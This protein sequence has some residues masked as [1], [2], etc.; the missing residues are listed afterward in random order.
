MIICDNCKAEVSEEQL[1]KRFGDIEITYLECKECCTE[2]VITVTDSKLRKMLEHT[3]ETEKILRRMSL[4]QK[5]KI[6]ILKIEYGNRIGKAKKLKTKH[7]IEK[8]FKRKVTEAAKK[9][10]NIYEPYKKEYEEMKNKNIKYEKELKEMY[11]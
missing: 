11:V 5:E 7:S 9:F 3:S 1:K 2:Y 10:E 4:D 8:E 6:D